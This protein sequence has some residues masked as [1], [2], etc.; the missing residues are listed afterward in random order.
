MLKTKGYL[1]G[2][3]FMLF[4]V[5]VL[6]Q[7]K[8]K[9]QLRKEKATN[10]EQIKLSE[11][12]LRA[13][14]NRKKASLGE[15]NALKYQ[16]NV[17]S[18]IINN[19]KAEN[20]LLSHEID[21]NEQIIAALDADLK[22]LKRE[23][24]A[25]TYAAYKASNS[26]DRLTFLFSATS[27]NQFIRRLQYLEQYSA[28]RIKQADQIK[29]V[30]DVLAKENENVKAKQAEQAILLKERLKENNNLVGLRNK[31]NRIVASLVKREKELKKDLKERRNAIAALNK[32]IDDIIKKEIANAKAASAATTNNLI[33]LSK[34]FEQNKLKLPWPANG[35]ISQK[36]G[37]S[38]DPILRNVERNSPGIDIQTKPDEMGQCI[39][40]GEV[41]AVASIPGFN[42]AVI[43]QHGEYRTVY[44]KLKKVLVKKGQK[45]KVGDKLGEIYIDND[46]IS[47]L[48]FQLWKG[49]QKLNP[50]SWLAK[51]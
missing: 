16:I 19:I 46:G 14:S 29:K 9:E 41:T 27:F 43:I 31:E 10:I 12:T 11:A 17:R 21:E 40:A 30:T 36:F 45:V 1:F 26:K 24:G 3:A 47:E 42:R 23:Y 20:K 35:F 49:G 4:S 48:H 8:T 7:G 22:D 18:K 15:L 33:V 50:E 13:T 38:R 6:G 28:S 2:M 25:M 39:F 44:A 34:N 51:R 37:K 32:L 5:T